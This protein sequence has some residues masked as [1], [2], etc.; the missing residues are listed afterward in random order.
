MDKKLIDIRDYAAKQEK[1]KSSIRQ[2]ISVGSFLGPYTV[3]FFLFF[4]F[5]LLLGIVMAFGTFNSKSFFPETVGTLK[6]F[7]VLFGDTA[8][9]RDFWNSVETTVKFA[10]CIVLELTV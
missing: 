9:A 8:I 6:N 10:F 2:M 7:Q 5:P 1:K 3:S 4:V